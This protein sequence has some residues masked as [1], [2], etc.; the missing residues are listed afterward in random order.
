MK[1]L[2][3]KFDKWLFESFKQSSQG[4]GLYR[5]FYILFLLFFIRINTLIWI[6]NNPDFLYKPPPISI[7]V[8]FN[9]FPSPIFLSLIYILS[10]IFSIF[11]LFGFKTKSSSIL[12]SFFL[13]LGK[14]F[15]YSFG[16]INHDILVY[17]IP[18]FMAFS[19]WGKSYSL[20]TRKSEKYIQD[21]ESNSWALGFIA[22]SLGIGYFN[23]GLT[24]FLGGYLDVTSSAVYHHA[25]IY[26]I[27][28]ETIV[29]PLFGLGTVFWESLDYAVVISEG[30]FL[31][32][33]F[34]RRLLTIF[35]FLSICFH[36]GNTIL[37]KISFIGNLPCYLLFLNWTL[38]A[39]FLETKKLNLLLKKIIN[40]PI[41]SFTLIITLIQGI[42]LIKRFPHIKY[43]S[44]AFHPQHLTNILAFTISF[45][46]L[47]L[48]TWLFYKE[49]VKIKARKKIE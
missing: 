35:I 38:I 6:G 14:T 44:F 5:I 49:K 37:F 8:F 32:A 15:T 22:I 28:R 12:L 47:F 42:K 13:I 31:V 17:I 3:N 45:S 27:N 9:G 29:Q 23:S 10:L 43:F 19:D 33:I 2:V 41:F 18:F 11:V 39:K 16:R 36:I 30:L 7:G 20:D 1:N 26:F 24:K 4:L 21:S 40:Y 34:N 48:S 46:L 25:F